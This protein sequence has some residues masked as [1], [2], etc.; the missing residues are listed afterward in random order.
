MAEFMKKVN[1]FFPDLWYV[2]ILGYHK[3]DFEKI[4]YADTGVAGRREGTEIKCK[5]CG[6]TYSL[7]YWQ[8]RSHLSSMKYESRD[9]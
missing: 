8:K 5:G 7:D 9:P 6:E 4:G 3:H 1:E 2:H